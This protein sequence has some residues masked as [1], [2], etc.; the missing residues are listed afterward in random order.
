MSYIKVLQ[1]IDTKA[2]SNGAKAYSHKHAEYYYG[3]NKYLAVLPTFCRQKPVV[4]RNK[5]ND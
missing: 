4:I 2:N 1:L 3:Y 5:F